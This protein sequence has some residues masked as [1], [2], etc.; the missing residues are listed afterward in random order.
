VIGY[1][2]WIEAGAPAVAAT[3]VADF[4]ATMRGH[5][6][7]V[8]IF[9]NAAHQRA[10]P[11]EDHMPYSSTPWPGPQP[12][13]DVLAC[14]VM[15]GGALDW[16]TLGERIVADKNAGNPAA[17]WIKYVNYTDLAGRCWHASWTPAYSRTSS[18]DTGH[19]HISARTDYANRHT[20]YDPIANAQTPR[21]AAGTQ[22][23]R[24]I[25]EP[26]PLGRGA[27][28]ELAFPFGASD[29]PGMSIATDTGPS[30]RTKAQWRVAKHKGGGAWAV[31]LVTT[32]TT[33]A[34]RLDVALEHGTDRVTVTRNPID[35][36]D[37]CDTLASVLGWW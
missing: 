2:G 6:Y 26:I 4:A 1:L 29:N 28:V 16:R 19:I 27:S 32:D 30:G 3:C 9:G 10:V 34:R 14:D 21:L 5:R 13:P 17:A 31:V 23:D 12:Y 11:P 25:H 15:P 18:N 37:A 36:T 7:T 22:E 35:A 20:T 24:V 33:D 8:Y